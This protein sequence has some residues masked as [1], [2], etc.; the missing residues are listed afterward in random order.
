[1]TGLKLGIVAI[2]LHYLCHLNGP[3]KD[4]AFVICT[5]ISGW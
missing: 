2:I 1:M 4:L 3:S 5:V